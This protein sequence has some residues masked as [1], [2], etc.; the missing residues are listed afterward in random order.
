[1]K[2]KEIRSKTVTELQ[3]AK[4]S[5]E[6]KLLGLRFGFILNDD[7]KSPAKINEA[8]RDIARINTVLRE[9]QLK[10]EVGNG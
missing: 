10:D 2:A 7:K 4:S 6:K 9:K 3:E 1:M 8:R 5:L